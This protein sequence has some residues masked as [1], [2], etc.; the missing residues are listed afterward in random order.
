[1]VGSSLSAT[2]ER[3]AVSFCFVASW[4]N[5]AYSS[6][7][8]DMGQEHLDV[9]FE[10]RDSGSRGVELRSV[11]RVGAGPSAKEGRVSFGRGGRGAVMKLTR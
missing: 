1:M 8:I 6:V 7:L 11:A 3:E 5:V 2:C 10:D 4:G 9:R